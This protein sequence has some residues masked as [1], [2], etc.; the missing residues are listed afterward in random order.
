MEDLELQSDDISLLSYG[1]LSPD[2][3]QLNSSFP[4]SDLSFKIPGNFSLSDLYLNYSAG[5]HFAALNFT[6][7]E[8]FEQFDAR[9]L[10]NVIAYSVMSAGRNL[11]HHY[12]ACYNFCCTF[13]NNNSFSRIMLN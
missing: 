7:L 11:Y 8:D 5:E 10:M 3:L 1:G 2:D 6:A 9:D 13:L 4:D 12:F